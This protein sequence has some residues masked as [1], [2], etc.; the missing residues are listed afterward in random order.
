M[1][2]LFLSLITAATLTACDEAASIDPAFVE[3][4]ASL[5]RVPCLDEEEML[6][7][8]DVCA[9]LS[10]STCHDSCLAHGHCPG[11]R[12]DNL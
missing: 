11:S 5:E 8:I 4:E 7:C 9:E 1:R 6:E 12:L 3:R 2:V 10:S